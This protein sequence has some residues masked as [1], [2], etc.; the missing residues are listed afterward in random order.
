MSPPGVHDPPGGAHNSFGGP[1]QRS[2]VLVCL[3]WRAERP[4]APPAGRTRRPDRVRGRNT[5]CAAAR[6]QFAEC[7][8]FLAASQIMRNNDAWILHATLRALSRLG[9]PSARA[10]PA[11]RT[12]SVGI[13]RAPEAVRLV[14]PSPAATT[15][16]R[17]P[18][19]C[20]IYP[21]AAPRIK[22]FRVDN[23]QAAAWRICSSP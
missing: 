18:R 7:S 20:S 12:H 17:P 23:E 4:W 1:G 22:R 15:I 3:S 8:E 9:L 14:Y 5:R 19:R 13:A 6:R 2:L 16:D 11:R 10:R 21:S